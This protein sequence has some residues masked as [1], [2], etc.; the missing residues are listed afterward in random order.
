M[1]DW[2]SWGVR[3]G[4]ES[5]S[6]AG[7]AWAKLPIAMRGIPQRASHIEQPSLNPCESAIHRNLH[8]NRAAVD[9][10]R[11]PLHWLDGGR[12]DKPMGRKRDALRR[13]GCAARSGRRSVADAA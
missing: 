9:A 6:Q 8:S 13:L 2:M 7:C 5:G 3:A 4:L 11:V 10:K 1:G 12:D